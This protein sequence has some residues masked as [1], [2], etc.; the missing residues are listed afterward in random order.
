MRIS[1]DSFFFSFLLSL[2]QHC[3]CFILLSPSL[4]NYEQ[5]YYYSVR[6]QKL[7]N[8]RINC[9]EVDKSFC[10]LIGLARRIRWGR[11]KGTL[12]SSIVL[13]CHPWKLKNF[14]TS[15]SEM[16]HKVWYIIIKFYMFHLKYLCR[17][18]YVPYFKSQWLKTKTNAAF[19]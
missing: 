13:N 10:G 8:K 17:K 19:I 9:L 2:S 16:L 14:P 4:C 11:S 1:M 18:F 7:H 6:I 15:K 12:I 5:W 3:L